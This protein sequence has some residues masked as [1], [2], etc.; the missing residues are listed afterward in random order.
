LGRK[1]F[2]SSGLEEKLVEYLLLTE[3]K[4]FGCTRGDV[5]RLDFQLA[6]QNKIPSPISIAKEAADKD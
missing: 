6:V 4:Y 3:R 5:R 1:P 2:I